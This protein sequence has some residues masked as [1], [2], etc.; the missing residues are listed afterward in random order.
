[1]KHIILPVITMLIIFNSC[2]NTTV[3]QSSLD[4]KEANKIYTLIAD[5]NYN[6]GENIKV[7]NAFIEKV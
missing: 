4:A 5:Y 1:M 7:K 2:K 3:P 6:E